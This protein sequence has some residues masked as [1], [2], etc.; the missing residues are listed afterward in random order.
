M[1]RIFLLLF[2]IIS[3]LLSSCSFPITFWMLNNTANDVT[4]IANEKN[5]QIQAGE[6][7]EAFGLDYKF[8]IIS[9][10][11]R[12]IYEAKDIPL[13]YVHWTGWGPFSKRMFYTQLDADGKVWVLSEK[14]QNPVIKFIV[15]PFGFPLVPNT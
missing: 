7:R 2:V 3:L 11:E 5:I 10:Y 8:S 6:S 14:T 9:K 13:S 12:L 1:N 4:I 15:Q